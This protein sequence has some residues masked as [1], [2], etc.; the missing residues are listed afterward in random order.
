MKKS[1]FLFATV[2]F[3]AFFTQAPAWSAL[4]P[5]YSM[6]PSVSFLPDLEADDFYTPV[7][8]KDPKKANWKKGDIWGAYKGSG[9]EDTKIGSETNLGFAFAVGGRYSENIRTEAEL[10][11]RHIGLKTIKGTSLLDGDIKIAKQDTA[12]DPEGWPT[13]HWKEEGRRSS[14]FHKKVKGYFDAY[15]FLIHVC[16]DFPNSS[17]I[18]PYLN[19]GYGGVYVS[20]YGVEGKDKKF[21]EIKDSNAFGFAYQVGGGVGI[22]LTK[23]FV[24]DCSYSYFDT[25]LKLELKGKND[26]K[27]FSRLRFKGSHNIGLGVRYVF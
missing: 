18:T 23:Q 7:S 21:W 2:L 14:L 15:S 8:F 9:W 5:Y 3:F 11:Y 19:V 10:G 1:S 13:N 16:Y 12:Q 6:K 25:P 27:Y 26:S 20:L 24:L 4:Q 17:V 22:A